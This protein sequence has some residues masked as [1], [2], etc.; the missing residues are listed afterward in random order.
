MIQNV[1]SSINLYFSYHED[2]TRRL[3]GRLLVLSFIVDTLCEPFSEEDRVYPR[4]VNT[5]FLVIICLLI[6]YSL[7]I[8]SFNN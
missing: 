6:L 5:Q 4:T 8:Q 7:I 1:Y 2:L 3:Q